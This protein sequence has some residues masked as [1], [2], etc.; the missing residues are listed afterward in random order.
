MV[1]VGM[2]G[3]SARSIAREAGVNQALVFYHFGSVVGL[4]RTA[5]Q[6][7]TS[8]AIARYHDRFAAANSLTEL[9]AVGRQLHETE[10]RQ[11]N[12]RVLAQLLAASQSDP[13]LAEVAR[14]SLELWVTEISAVTARLLRESPITELVDPTDLARTISASFIGLELYAGADPDGAEHAFSSLDRLGALLVVL[15]ELNPIER[16]ALERKLR[17][18]RAN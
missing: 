4:V 3:L 16:R 18:H 12:V 13:E 11:G 2:S 5:A 14:A 15:E 1:E 17:R 10:Q 6:R 7:S 9:L 8:E